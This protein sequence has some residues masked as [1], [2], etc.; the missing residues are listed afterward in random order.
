M[1]VRQ[2]RS[3]ENHRMDLF[4]VGSAL[5]FFR[6]HSALKIQKYRAMKLFA[7]GGWRSGKSSIFTAQGEGQEG[8]NYTTTTRR[9]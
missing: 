8:V 3:A 7:G 5:L 1:E 9:I 2:Y 4:E 6:K